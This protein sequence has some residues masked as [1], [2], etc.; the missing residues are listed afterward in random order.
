MDRI[1]ELLAGWEEQ[2][3]RG[4]A[5]SPEELYPDDAELREELRRRIERRL[6]LLARME[7]PTIASPPP[8]GVAATPP[9]LEGYDI[10]EVLGAGG[11]GVVYKARQR[12]LHR[13]VALKMIQSGLGSSA[14]DDRFQLE[15]ITVAK[16]QHPNIVT[17]YEVGE[18]DGRPFLALEYVEGGNLAR[19]LQGRPDAAH[20]AAELVRVLA[21][22]VQ[23]AHEQGIVHRD[24]K[25]ANVL[26]SRDGAPKITH[27]GLAKRLDDD[28]HHTRTGAVLSTPSYMAPEQATGRLQ[29]IGP[30]TDVYALG[31]ILYEMLTGRLPFVG[32]TVLDTLEQVRTASPIPP[33][34]FIAKLP[35]DLETICLRCLEKGPQQRYVSAQELAEDVR[36]F[37]N[38]EP[39]KARS[40]TVLQQIARAVARGRAGFPHYAQWGRVFL[41]VSPFPLLIH[42]AAVLLF[43]GQTFYVPLMIGTSLATAWGVQTLVFRGIRPRWHFVP[44]RLRRHALLVWNLNVVAMVVLLL[45][46]W[47]DCPSDRPDQ[48]LLFYPLAMILVAMT[49]FS[50]AAEIGLF[51]IVGSAALA[52]AVLEALFLP[53]SPLIIGLF[54][55]LNTCGQGLFYRALAREL[56]RG[57]LVP[58][59]VEQQ[60]TL[61]HRQ[62]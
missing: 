35:K 39:I 28:M 4:R 61:S 7:P 43:H 49:F 13:I 17:V 2:R 23:H 22:S 14:I 46:L 57:S 47:W 34:Q 24:L 21:L 51:H 36:R 56:K 31:V 11:M 48:M 60:A 52:G 44:D 53:W 16:L 29:D 42:L 37:L 12:G 38:G 20:R 59:S 55:T 41:F 62:P 19:A 30:A 10:E 15:A 25:P 50:F 33:R 40:D 9:R 5:P 18:H 6:R 58:S 27:F 45:V 54:M 26:L 32:E 8:D 1:I 3:F